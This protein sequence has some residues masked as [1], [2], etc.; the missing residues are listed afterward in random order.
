MAAR[1]PLAGTPTS[2]ECQTAARVPRGGTAPPRVPP[3]RTAPG[4][5]SRRC[6]GCTVR[7][8]RRRRQCCALRGGT[9]AQPT[10]RRASRVLP[11]GT[12]HQARTAATAPRAVTPARTRRQGPAYVRLAHLASTAW[13]ARARVCCVR[14]ACGRRHKGLLAATVAATARRRLGCTVPRARRLRTRCLVRLA[15]TPSRATTGS[16]GRRA[17]RCRRQGGTARPPTTAR[18]RQCR[19]RAPSVCTPPPSGSRRV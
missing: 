4:S 13:R 9:A 15:R 18:R 5:V 10:Q 19:S 11:D 16:A 8:V 7:L 2:R 14:R 17:A 3:R 6:L 1:V 12:A